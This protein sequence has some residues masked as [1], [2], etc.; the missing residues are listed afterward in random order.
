MTGKAFGSIKELADSDLRIYNTQCSGAVHT[1][2]R[3]A[4][5]YVCRWACHAAGHCTRADAGT[6]FGASELLSV[7]SV[8]QWFSQ[9]QCVSFAADVC[10]ISPKCWPHTVTP[11]HTLLCS[12]YISEDMPAGSLRDGTRHEDLQ[13]TSFNDSTFDL[14]ISSEVSLS[15]P[16]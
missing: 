1:S 13:H 6:S 16:G 5:R 10:L 15:L 2:L 9:D 14:I 3:N 11:V 7:L 4:P 12:E 8:L